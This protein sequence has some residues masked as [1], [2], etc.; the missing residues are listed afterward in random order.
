MKTIYLVI[1][2]GLGNQLFQAALGLVL[3][4]RLGAEIRYL[5]D[6]FAVDS[7][8]RS[9]LLQSFPALR[10]PCVTRA[11]TAAAKTLKEDALAPIPVGDRVGQIVAQ[12]SSEP[13]LIVDGYWQDERYWEDHHALVRAA[14]VP[15][16]A[17]NV[18]AM[19]E[20][21]QTLGAI[22]VHLRRGDYGHHGLARTDYYIHSL[23][24]IREQTGVA[25]AFYGADEP[26]FARFIFRH[27]KDLVPLPG[28]VQAPLD[29]F[30]LLSR[31]RHFVIAN[32][33]FSWW[34]A[35]LGEQ[36][37]SIIYAPQPWCLFD[38]LFN[39]APSRWRNVE[40]AVQRQ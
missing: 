27:I 5:T 9:Y 28:N 29:D 25:L 33:S 7:Y 20:Q 30:Y 36:P 14:M 10:R 31:C 3:E 32:S 22:G 15:D 12:L 38:P 2:G 11:E 37:G 21:I 19:G 18:A 40:D 8:D 6:I 17:P 24:A 34:A 35:W 26:N 13:A 39:A 23:A 16:I 4:A 1:K